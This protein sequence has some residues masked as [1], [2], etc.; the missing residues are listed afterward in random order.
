MASALSDSTDL[1][2]A[3]WASWASGRPGLPLRFLIS[4]GEKQS[5]GFLAELRAAGLGKSCNCEDFPSQQVPGPGSPGLSSSEH[6]HSP[7]SKER[8]LLQAGKGLYLD[9]FP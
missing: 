9:A 5:Q 2:S 1:L 4:P 7:G 8:R 6:T 3:R